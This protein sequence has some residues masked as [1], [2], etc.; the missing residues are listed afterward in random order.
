[1][2]N[3]EGKKKIV[4]SIVKKIRQL[5]P[6]GR[7]LKFEPSIN[8]WIDIGNERAL[9][10]TRQALREGIAKEDYFIHFLQNIHKLENNSSLKN[11]QNVD[12]ASQFQ[13][14]TVSNT[15]LK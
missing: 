8:Q 2:A 3:N 1:M 13:E 11:D 9:H 12:K 5:H 6:P 15:L 4:E 14:K 10:K 7:F